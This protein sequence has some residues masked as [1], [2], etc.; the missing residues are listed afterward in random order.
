MF[1]TI[2]IL[3][4]ALYINLAGF[5]WAGSSAGMNIKVSQSTSSEG[6][7]SQNAKTDTV[8]NQMSNVNTGTVKNF[9]FLCNC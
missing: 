6:S 5:G 8:Y 2:A 9:I 1:W 4:V 3:G 7:K